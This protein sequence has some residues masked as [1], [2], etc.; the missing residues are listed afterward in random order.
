MIEDDATRV[1]SEL[2]DPAAARRHAREPR[3]YH[4]AVDLLLKGVNTSFTVILQRC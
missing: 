2:L 4:Q 1:R 3:E